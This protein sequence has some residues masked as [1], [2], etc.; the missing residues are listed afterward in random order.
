[1]KIKGNT[2]GTTMPRA[3]LNQT[4]PKKADYVVGREMVGEMIHID[5]T[6]PIEHP[7]P[8]TKLWIDLDGEADVAVLCS[9]QELTDEQKA[10]AKANLGLEEGGNDIV[11]DEALSLDS[12]NPVQNKVITE[13][14]NS[15]M[16]KGTDPVP[17]LEDDTPDF[18]R[19][20]GA[21][22]WEITG[23]GQ[24]NIVDGGTFFLGTIL[25]MPASNYVYQVVFAPVSKSAYVRTAASGNTWNSTWTPLTYSKQELVQGVLDALPTWEGGA[26]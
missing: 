22:A 13:A 3:N 1:M 16:F 23:A 24:A 10:Q 12:T 21:G 6:E 4:D 14:I 11:I 25:N 8:N 15:A 2:V 9:P 18:W 26:Y 19:N 20:L 7:D 17:S 5:Y